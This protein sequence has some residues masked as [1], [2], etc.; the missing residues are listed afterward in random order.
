M[1]PYSHGQLFSNGAHLD[2]VNE[3]GSSPYGRYHVNRFCH[4]SQIGTLLQGRLG[5]GIDAVGALYG[6][7]NGKGNERFLSL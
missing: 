1:L 6:V 5:K 4:L 3:G 7:C 2:A